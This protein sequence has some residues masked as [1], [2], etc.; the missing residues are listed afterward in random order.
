MKKTDFKSSDDGALP[1]PAVPVSRK[2]AVGK[3]TSTRPS[4]KA[5]TTKAMTGTADEDDDDDEAGDHI[6]EDPDKVVPFIKV[7]KTDSDAAE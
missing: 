3:L 7:E 2:R 4:K 6:K 5:K 1:A